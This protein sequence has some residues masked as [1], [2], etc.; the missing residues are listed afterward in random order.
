MTKTANI[1]IYRNHEVFVSEVRNYGFYGTMFRASNGDKHQ[2]NMPGL[3][4]RSTA[5]EAQQDLDKWAADRRLS[6]VKK[7]KGAAK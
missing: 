3:P 6:V 2:I 1:Y 5:E 7:K 4:N